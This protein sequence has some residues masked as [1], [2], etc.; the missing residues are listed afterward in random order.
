MCSSVKHHGTPADCFAAYGNQRKETQRN[1]SNET[2]DLGKVHFILGGGGWA[3]A[4]EG[5]V[6]SK[7]FGK[8]GG[9][10]FFYLW[11]GEGHNFFVSAQGEGQHFW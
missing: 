10:Q 5:R 11:L 8:W 4:S 3:G 2:R 6:I 1:K 7:I 9:P